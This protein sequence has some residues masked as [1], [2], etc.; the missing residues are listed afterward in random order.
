MN[1]YCDVVI[2]ELLEY[3]N[4][5]VKWFELGVILQLRTFSN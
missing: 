5:T 3:F 1:F 4:R 2:E